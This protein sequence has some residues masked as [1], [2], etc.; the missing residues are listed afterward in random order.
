MSRELHSCI[1]QDKAVSGIRRVITRSDIQ[2]ALRYINPKIK[3]KPQ[4]SQQITKSRT[5][6]YAT[7]L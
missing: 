5:E 7:Y 4:M 2:A 6:G 1:A 3:R